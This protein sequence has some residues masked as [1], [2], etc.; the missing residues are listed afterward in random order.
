MMQGG[1]IQCSVIVWRGE[2]GW[3]VG[4]GRSEGGSK[5]RGHTCMAETNTIL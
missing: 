1:Q 2:M 5:G 4:G 3:E